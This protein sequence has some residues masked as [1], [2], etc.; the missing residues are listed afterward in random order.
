MVT[1][2]IKE[3]AQNEAELL[4]QHIR[5][6]HYIVRKL[7][8]NYEYDELVQVG[9]LALLKAIRTFDNTKA[10][11]ATYASR[12]IT[13]QLLMHHR[14]NSKHIP[15]LSLDGEPTN[16]NGDSFSRYD[17][18]DAAASDETGA[19]ETKIVFQQVVKKLS[20]RE[21]KILQLRLNGKGQK[22]IGQLLNISQGY[23]S[24]IEKRVPKR[25]SVHLE[26]YKG[27]GFMGCHRRDIIDPG[28]PERK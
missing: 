15:V 3:P 9:T 20:P 12:C 4:E 17:I 14:R 21:L 16:D 22:E 5:L 19:V 7:N 8:L 2:S 27:D 10:A 11:F 25:L 24:R 6:V 18:L 23:V 13:N 28:S 26:P 1:T